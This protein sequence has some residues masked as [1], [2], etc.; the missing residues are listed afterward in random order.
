MTN[1]LKRRGFLGAMGGA[2]ALSAMSPRMAM[3]QGVNIDIA[4]MGVGG[5]WY[6][7]GITLSQY[8]GP[9][10]PAGSVVTVRDF[11][12]GDGNLRLIEA[13]QRVQV[14]LTFAMNISWS[15]NRMTHITDSTAENVRLI[16]GGLDQFYLGMMALRSLG[17]TTMSEVWDAGRGLRI[18]TTQPGSTGEIATGLLLQAHGLDEAE[19]S[20][21]GGSLTRVSMQAASENMITD[22]ADVWINMLVAGQPRA[23]ELAFSH[24]MT[25]LSLSDEA[26]AFMTDHGFPPA[27]LP[28][29]TFHRQTEA[30]R[31]PATETV[32]IVN[33]ELD[34]DIAYRITM[35]LI[36]NMEAIRGETAALSNFTPERAVDVERAGGA[37]LHPGAERAYREAGFI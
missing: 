5:L 14:A 36:E 28:A 32:I 6:Q 35:S 30:V 24:D 21:R 25:F 27:Y 17:A 11:A 19:N 10:L 22:R 3:A 34:D 33:S 2:A 1:G 7:Y 18:S 4:T 8:I 13:N 26:Q 15:R 29:D 12:G 23:T 31:L 20:R 37:P 16:A 9:Y